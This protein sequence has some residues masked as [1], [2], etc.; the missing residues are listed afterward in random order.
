MDG[1]DSLGVFGCLVYI[2][3][4][5]VNQQ[6]KKQRKGKDFLIYKKEEVYFSILNLKFVIIKDIIE[7]K[8]KFN[9]KKIFVI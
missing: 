1:L 9:C 4:S 6:R 7:L 8:G 3:R 5:L 2:R